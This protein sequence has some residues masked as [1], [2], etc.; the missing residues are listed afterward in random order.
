MHLYR[1]LFK[2]H[3]IPLMSIP[4]SFILMSISFDLMPIS[5]ILMSISFIL[6]PIS[7]VLMPISFIL[8]SISFDHMPI[9]FIQDL[10]SFTHYPFSFRYDM[11][12]LYKE[13]YSPRTHPFAGKHIS[14]PHRLTL[15]FKGSK[16][17]LPSVPTP[18]PV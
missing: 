10:F 18:S 5:L 8:M 16:R 7:F 15:Q 1:G 12:P 9:S 6:M 3:S 2:E 14:S 13:T 17:A 11:I 4:I